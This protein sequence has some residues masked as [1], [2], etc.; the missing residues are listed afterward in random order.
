M[1]LPGMMVE[2]LAEQ[3]MAGGSKAFTVKL[4]LQLAIWPGFAPCE[5]C[6]LTV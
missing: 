6:P 5:A 4:A 3:L 2:G 1:E